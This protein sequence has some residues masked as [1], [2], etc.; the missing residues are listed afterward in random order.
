[1]NLEE[2]LDEMTNLEEDDQ[3]LVTRKPR[4]ATQL[5]DI[6]QRRS[7]GDWLIVRDNRKSAYGITADIDRSV[8]WKFGHIDKKGNYT[9][10]MVKER[11]DKIVSFMCKVKQNDMEEISYLNIMEKI[12]KIANSNEKEGD[13]INKHF[14]VQ[15][16]CNICS[17]WLY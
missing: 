1:M 13:D 5:Q 6:L 16:H 8:L 11:T 17:S 10:E 15:S 12:D 9:N 4:G 14:K 7:D 2:Y 3:D